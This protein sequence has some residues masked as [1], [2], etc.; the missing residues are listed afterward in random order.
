MTVPDLHDRIRV[1]PLPDYEPEVGVSPPTRWSSLRPV[2]GPQL[3]LTPPSTPG[4]PPPA[5][6]VSLWRLL[7]R[8]LEVL[9]GRR[10]VAQLRTLLPDAAFEALL[11][12]LRTTGPGHRHVLRRIRT[13]YPTREVVEVS[14]VIWVTSTT[15][16]D[17][18]IAAAGRFEREDDEWR[19]TVLR[20]M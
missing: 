8:V 17:R 12:R 3:A 20:L 6:P 10:P 9:D 16:R 4:G 7:T 1:R 14:A 2:S 11:T 5:S 15:G 13:C 19:C 18:A